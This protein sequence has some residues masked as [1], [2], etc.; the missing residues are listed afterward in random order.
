[1]AEH[2]IRNAGVMGSTPIA[3]F[4]AARLLFD[5]SIGISC[6]GCRFFHL[7]F[8]VPFGRLRGL[9]RSCEP[10]KALARNPLFSSSQL[11]TVPKSGKMR[12]SLRQARQLF[13][14]VACNWQ[15]HWLA[16]WYH[17]QSA[18]PPLKRSLFR[19]PRRRWARPRR[20]NRERTLKTTRW[21]VRESLSGCAIGLT[22]AAFG[23][24]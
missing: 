1:M 20:S 24:E 3:G 11:K 13:I 18:P 12:G 5:D 8:P 4:S 9:A 22:N 21:L 10:D 19:R 15:A 16:G 14:P 6:Q 7:N 23:G 2:R 17:P